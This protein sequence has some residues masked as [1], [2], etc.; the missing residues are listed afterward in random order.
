MDI[1]NK[2]PFKKLKAKPQLNRVNG[3]ASSEKKCDRPKCNGKIASSSSDNISSPSKAVVATP[4]LSSI[5][6]ANDPFTFVPGQLCTPQVAFAAS[7]E[8]PSEKTQP[9]VQESD[10]FE[11]S[12][13][14]AVDSDSET[15]V[16]EEVLE[17]VDNPVIHENDQEGKPS[18]PG[19]NDAE[20][21]THSRTEDMT[22]RISDDTFMDADI[23]SSPDN[24]GRKRQR[25]GSKWTRP[26]RM[27]L[28]GNNTNSSMDS[29]S[30]S[31]G[32][33]LS[34]ESVSTISESKSVVIVLKPSQVKSSKKQA[35][36]S[37]ESSV[38]SSRKSL[39]SMSE[40]LNKPDQTS[41][42]ENLVS[43]V[44]FEATE[45]SA[46]HKLLCQEGEDLTCSTS[47]MNSPASTKSTKPSVE[48]SVVNDIPNVSGDTSDVK[49][50]DTKSLDQL[51]V[52]NQ[53][54]KSPIEAKSNAYQKRIIALQKARAA[55]WQKFHQKIKERE[56]ARKNN[57]RNEAGISSSVVNPEKSITR[58]AKSSF[59]NMTE[60][61]T[62]SYQSNETTQAEDYKAS[63]L[64]KTTTLRRKRKVHR[65]STQRKKKKKT[66]IDKAL[67]ESLEKPKL[68]KKDRKS[69]KLSTRLL[70]YNMYLA[71]N[72]PAKMLPS[73]SCRKLSNSVL[74][75]SISEDNNEGV[76]FEDEWVPLREQM[77]IPTK[78]KR[79]K[80]AH[81]RLK[82]NTV[83]AE[84]DIEDNFFRAVYDEA[85]RATE[86]KRDYTA[87]CNSSD[88]IVQ[89]ES[90]TVVHQNPRRWSRKKGITSKRI[91][92]KP[93][94]NK[95]CK[96]SRRKS[97]SL[98]VMD[99]VLQPENIN[100]LSDQSYSFTSVKSKHSTESA[101]QQP[102]SST[103][104]SP[105]N[106]GLKGVSPVNSA[107][108]EW[109][110]S[111]II[112]TRQH[113]GGGGF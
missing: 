21:L 40:S 31:S 36:E 8:L 106:S 46:P 69:K 1:L 3:F 77:E 66:L 109:S 76:D 83:P 86:N 47:L 71:E 12:E 95:L 15:S 9:P 43:G 20:N 96:L 99:Q 82:K 91:G 74:S 4:L 37:H 111:F 53:A 64:K 72:L 56:D 24:T 6:L 90:D 51:S 54:P 61:P 26:K 39:T 92:V 22:N 38:K 19:G 30:T 62:E 33:I 7:T 2:M 79:A 35:V 49:V 88:S 23:T 42:V 13:N 58:S 65:F 81:K 29:L 85:T 113:R 63:R 34:S 93:R 10:G 94:K 107:N 48:I 27:C 87:L 104:L 17:E 101:V 108:T 11:S 75:E 105:D 60:E 110:V 84:P 80:R 5:V 100:V 68:I 102:T 14:L 98:E 78:S 57:H 18:A 73:R 44:S 50:D 67:N 16:T 52:E 70:D 103:S 25:N 45:T 97:F 41:Q 28:P 32:E 89:N 55:R 59:I 112:I